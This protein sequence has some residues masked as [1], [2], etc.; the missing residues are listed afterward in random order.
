VARHR[1]RVPA[2]AL[3]RPRL[4]S[5]RETDREH[6]GSS[7]GPSPLASALISQRPRFP[8]THPFG[9]RYV[10]FFGGT[11]GGADLGLNRQF[12]GFTTQSLSDYFAKNAKPGD[13][14][15]I[16]DTAWPS[17]QRM[18][19]EK[20]LPPSLQGVGSPAE[21]DFSIVHHEQHINEVDYNIWTEYRSV[22][23]DYVLVHD[24]VPIIS[25]YRRPQSQ[26]RGARPGTGRTR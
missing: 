18:I 1:S 4:R 15:Y 26:T 25:V 7:R 11:A 21:A 16:M 24:G 19:D 13:R 6:A 12:W 17:W 22:A 10:P 5:R 23:P 14:V 2:L 8:R 3:R 20:R 9:L